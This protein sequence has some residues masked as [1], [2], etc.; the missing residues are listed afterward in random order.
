MIHDSLKNA[1]TAYSLNPRLKTAFEYIKNNDL[2]KMAPGKITLDGENLF[3]SIMEID[4]KKKEDAK[5]EAH[6]KYIDIQVVLLGQET[7]GWIAIENCKNKI[8][9]YNP[10]KDI[11]FFKDRPTSYVTVN[12]GEFSIFFPEDAH[13][14]AIGKGPIKKI[15]VKVLASFN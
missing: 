15:I 12:P 8:D 14:P 3:I 11:I 5:T 4:G 13:A 2:S 1:A 10:D 7:M 9:A 6:K